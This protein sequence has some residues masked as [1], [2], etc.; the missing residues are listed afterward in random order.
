MTT[1][2]GVTQ[3]LKVFEGDSQI[4]F[5]AEI[6]LLIVLDAQGNIKRVNPSFE[7]TL[8]R[9]ER[10]VLGLPIVALVHVD[11]MAKFIRSFSLMTSTYPFRLLCKDA[12]SVLVDLMAFRFRRIDEEA[13]RRGYLILRPLGEVS[14]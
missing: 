13:G 4:F 9:P 7:R 5:D 3:F 1:R 2:R 8:H 10:E 6:D 14:E 11:D 12:G